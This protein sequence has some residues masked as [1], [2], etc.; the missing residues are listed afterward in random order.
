M[1][2]LILAASF[3][4]GFSAI[5]KAAEPITYEYFDPATHSIKT[6]TVTD[7]IL[8]TDQTET[9]EDGKWYVVEGPKR[10]TRRGSLTVKGSANLLLR[11]GADYYVSH[12]TV[13]RP[14]NSLTIWGE[15]LSGDAQGRFFCW[16]DGNNAGIGGAKSA[17]GT[18]TING[19]KIEALAPFA[20]AG[21]GGAFG[22]PGGTVTINGGT[23]DSQSNLRGSGI[24]GGYRG[25]G[26]TVTIN[27]GTV[28][29]R[30]GIG[31]GIGSGA[32]P[33]TNGG[34]VTINGGTVV[35]SSHTRGMGI[36]M[37]GDSAG[38]SKQGSLRVGEAMEVFGGKTSPTDKIAKQGDDYPR[39]Q[40]MLVQAGSGIA[41]SLNK[42]T[43]NLQPGEVEKLIETLSPLDKNAV[44][45]TWTSSNPAVATVSGDGTVTAF[46]EG[47]A[48]ITIT[49]D[50]GTPE[51]PSD[52]KSAECNVLVARAKAAFK[53]YPDRVQS[54]YTGEPIALAMP[55]ET[56]DGTILYGVTDISATEKPAEMT[57]Q[58]PTMKNAGN[59]RV[60]FYI[61]GDKDHRDSDLFWWNTSIKTK[62]ITIASGIKAKNKEYDGT[63]A[64][65]LDFSGI[66]WT[67]AG[68]VAADAGKLSLTGT[69]RF[70]QSDIGENIPVS[71]SNL[72]LTGESAANYQLEKSANQKSTSANITVR[73]LRP[74]DISIQVV[75]DRF[76]YRGGAIVPTNITVKD[77]GR[78]PVVLLKEGTDY[79]LSF[80]DNVNAGTAKV[81]LSPVA[82]STVTFP[83][84]EGA[85]FATFTI[86]KR[87]P[88]VLAPEAKSLTYN[89][90][91]QD[92]ITEGEA[93][94]AVMQ[95]ALGTDDKTAPSAEDWSTVV[96][97]AVNAGTYYV[98]YRA[99]GDQN[100]KDT[101]P[102]CVKAEI[103]KAAIT[104]VKL[105]QTIFDE[106]GSEI[107]ATVKENGVKA[108]ELIVPATAYDVSDD[109][110]EHPG[111][112]RLKVTAKEDSNFSGSAEAV[113]RIV[114]REEDKGY[115]ISELD[116][117]EFP[118][119]GNM[120][121]PVVT[122][123]D[124]PSG[125]ILEAGKD[126][127][128]TYESNKDAGYG[129]VTV[130]GLGEY[131]RDF[132]KQVHTFTIQK[133]PLTVTA[134]DETITYG[135]D[136][137]DPGVS[138]LGFVND[139]NAGVL[140][141]SL[142]YTCNYDKETDTPGIYGITP[143][144]LTAKNYEI[145]FVPGKLTVNPQKIMITAEDKTGAYGE[146]AKPLTYQ[147]TPKCAGKEPKIE[148]WT[149]A[150]KGS[151]AGEYPIYL[152]WDGDLNYEATLV[153][154]TYTISKV[155]PKIDA[156][157]AAKEGL[158]YDGSA[159]E[160][161][162]A[163]LSADGILYYAVTDSKNR[164]DAS[165]YT[166]DLPEGTDAG[167]YY[168]WYMVKG[169][170]NHNELYVQEPVIA[171]IGKADSGD[172][173]LPEAAERTYTGSAQELVSAGEAAGA[174]MEYALGTD[175]KTA[176]T[177]GWSNA[178][179]TGTDAG[180]YYVWYRV[181]GDKDH[182]GIA[183]ACVTAAI[184]K[185]PSSVTAPAPRMLIYNGE[186]QTLVDSGA[187]EGGT[188]VY[189]VTGD[190]T[191]EPEDAAYAEA[192]PVGTE[193]GTYYVWYK[194]KGD[195]NHL[196]TAPACIIAE[197]TEK[198]MVAFVDE[199]GMYLL[200]EPKEYAAGTPAAEIER[201]EDPTKDADA[202]YTYSFAG[203]TPEITDVTGDA[204]YTATYTKTP[205]TYTLTYAYDGTVPDEAP[206][207]P[208][209][210]QHV[211][212]EELDQKEVPSVE[213]YIFSG[214][215][216][217]PDVMPAED[218]TVIG[219]WI[220][221][222]GIT[223]K[224]EH[225]QQN[226][227]NPEEYTLKETDTLVGAE[228]DIV[229]AYPESYPGFS[230]DEENSDISD[231]PIGADLVLRLYYVRDEYDVFFV[232]YD[233]TLLSDPG[234]YS[235]GTPAA[236]IERP[237]DPVREGSLRYTYA[238]AGW[239]PEITD[240]T[241]D[242]VYRAVYTAVPK[243]YTITFDP[244]GGWFRDGS[245]EKIEML[246]EYG[247][248]IQVI[249]APERDGYR[250]L[251]W[252]GS[253]Y[254]PGDAYKVIGDHT[255]K[256][257]WEAISPE[258]DDDVTPDKKDVTP[259]Q[260]D[261]SKANA[262]G[263]EKTGDENDLLLWVLLFGGSVFVIGG[264]AFLYRKRKG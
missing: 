195:A 210:E 118:Y 179:P 241:G 92:L 223:Y 187:S 188:L 73:T 264:S 190:S 39:F 248:T 98:W 160:L 185:A 5:V 244:S 103:G 52:D 221:G 226:L 127:S 166:D 245:T 176:P 97:K 86:D 165:A 137:E 133:V 56:S 229:K 204:V 108:G 182:E 128:V 152:Q 134:K 227:E 60:W 168:V 155:D 141:G 100:H 62:P 136:P 124:F 46:A 17:A 243:Q 44:K 84:G 157:P 240:V 129:K 154:G 36:G 94:G 23:V 104:N 79:T 57:A 113:F 246:C 59:Y 253:E 142:S 186:A 209:Q 257:K 144:G 199:D 93:E 14:G 206:A 196:D 220:A 117:D 63:D 49:A 205:K 126:Y 77:I 88:R 102:A 72:A 167:T 156:A 254:Y 12:G 71:I 35:A 239:A 19:G 87:E 198:Y 170:R 3:L 91:T 192:L 47:T 193:A 173:K 260:K 32:G 216:N 232:D 22:Y 74:E 149:A 28:T 26:G 161:I 18:I 78:N 147:I 34:T 145:T 130:T 251:Y 120:I 158:T 262:G 89:D 194:V 10:I 70:R 172:V 6:G 180:T 219:R 121:K 110:A 228:G 29:A 41:I 197:I 191:V 135:E 20:G 81:T 122:V 261:D 69:G 225:Y 40:Y 148:I 151:D 202:A 8:V 146:E 164:P 99:I 1:I 25:D 218:V 83:T 235:Y 200:Q 80:S 105:E 95:Y 9:L 119:T 82:G 109:R 51:D 53:K 213:G 153:N 177:E 15:S 162:R 125:A 65:E 114:D 175:D 171:S 116:K 42:N 48:K 255:L 76:V 231:C 224:V 242:A 238:F 66:D 101:D 189:S 61:K 184:Q 107:T 247:A 233:G 138:Y 43:L 7:Y 258:P 67:S 106:T 21:I 50:P 75:P 68:R 33:G 90:K 85:P 54:T 230:L 131:A 37:G 64:A 112:Y 203:W 58:I 174:V 11:N 214:W 111:E 132:N 215:L 45:L 159:Q 27:G 30:G 163:G 140:G 222:E 183:P 236:N 139:E 55:G 208:A 24:G 123:T 212:G 263:K 31:A 143:K 16:A 234:L 259:D 201:P 13:V 211:C 207:P 4:P 150:V 181:Q 256:A 237:E 249:E 250:F 178:V 169:D 252:E 96:P 38:K 2:A 217:E 115:F